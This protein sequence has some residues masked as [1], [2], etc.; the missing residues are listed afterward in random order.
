MK[1]LYKFFILFTLTFSLT[2]C[3][4]DDDSLPSI[5]NPE[6]VITTV[7]LTLTPETGG[8]SII[9]RSFDSDG[10]GPNA[11]IVTV[12]GDLETDTL[13]LGM[14]LFLNE[15]TTPSENITEEVQEEA[16]EHQVLYTIGSSLSASITPTDFD[17]NS[18][19][20]GTS[21]RLSTSSPSE[22]SLSITLRHEPK[23]PNDG[24]LLDAG[25]ETDVQVSF[26]VTVA[27]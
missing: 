21:I 19:P 15:T 16:D 25:G 3:I 14:V 8:S 18:N 12:S 5:V 2:S 26:P 4:S 24:T 27:N 6:E 1:T 10:D 13:Y 11:P 9:L 7:S 20:L 23:K 17:S 22:G